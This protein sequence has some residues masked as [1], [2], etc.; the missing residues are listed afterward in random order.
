VAIYRL[1]RSD[2]EDLETRLHIYSRDDTLYWSDDWSPEFYRLLA[3]A[4]FINIAHD[5]DELGP[6]L[7]PEMQESYAVLD[8]PNL[9]LSRSMQ[10]WRRSERCAEGEYT[11]R[12]GGDL[13]EILGG[14]ARTYGDSWLSASY[15]QLLH[16]LAEDESTDDFEVRTAALT[17]GKAGRVVAG[18]IGYRVGRVYTSLTGFFERDDPFYRNTG[19]LQLALLA[20]HLK[21]SGFA[22]WNLGHPGMAYKS[23]LGARDVP[24]LEFLR[25]WFAETG[26]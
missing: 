16:D 10:R 14:I 9:H 13:D 18:E 7:L 25:R 15:A 12:V 4:G 6:V 11:L 22:F 3:R 24:R 17:S 2:I 20:E 8:W 21:A 1:T 19:T 5:H 23:D 26:G